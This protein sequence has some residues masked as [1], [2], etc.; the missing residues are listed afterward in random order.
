MFP[1]SIYHVV[2]L[3]VIHHMGGGGGRWR[4]TITDC[5]RDQLWRVS[6]L[7]GLGVPLGDV[8]PVDNLP[9][10]LD[11]VRP[12]V[13]V[14]QVIGVL[15]NKVGKGGG[16]ESSEKNPR[17]K[18]IQLNKKNWS[19]IPPR[20]QCQE[21]EP[22]LNTTKEEPQREERREIERIDPEESEAMKERRA[23]QW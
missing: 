5:C 13:L 7:L 15:K 23:N 2:A 16:G 8:L 1:K 18:K 9:D 6:L 20:H 21:E 10:G 4:N 3:K 14:L 17:M 19:F 11:V 12:D 22:V